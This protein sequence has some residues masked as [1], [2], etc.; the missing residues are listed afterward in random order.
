MKIQIKELEKY[1]GAYKILDR[2]NLTFNEG[3]HGLLGPNGAGKTT[4]IRILSTLLSKT[5]GEIYYD[6]IKVDNKEEIRK[7]IGYLPQ[8]FSFYPNFTVYE[9]LDYFASLSNIK[10]NKKEILDRLEMVHLQDIYKAK[11]KTLSGGMKRRL[12]IAVAMVGD[13]EVLIVDEPTAGLD[14]E[15][16]IRVRNMLS[17]FGKTKTV[18]LSTHIVEDIQLSCKS[19]SILNK[20]KLIYSGTVKEIIK[21]AEGYVWNLNVNFGDSEQYMD[22]YNVI[23]SIADED[24][25]SLRIL[26]REKPSLNA[27]DISPTLEDAYMKFIKEV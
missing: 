10:L 21:E 22:K 24:K 7:I 18:L 23:S 26:S 9:T 16:R 14:P 4:L 17:N 11:T 1:Y 19:L 25:I 3:I 8:E 12:G 6:N 27:N 5:S 13:P 15:E 20:G 2:I